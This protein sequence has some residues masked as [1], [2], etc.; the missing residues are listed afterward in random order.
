MKKLVALSVLSLISL[1]ALAS[2]LNTVL[3]VEAGHKHT[4]L[5]AEIL[6]S[7]NGFFYNSAWTKNFRDGVNVAS[8]GVGYQHSVGLV[9]GYVGIKAAYIAPKK[10][11]NG[12]AAPFGGGV[13]IHMTNDIYAYGEGYVATRGM[14]NAVQKYVEV[15]SGVAYTPKENVVLN[16]GYRYMGVDG[17]SE[18]PNH[19]LIDGAY[20][21]AGYKF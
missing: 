10:G 14:N 11:D 15:D 21:G 1:P 19:A 12:F 20:V 9:D 5:S 16:V 6:P 4:Q 13:R 3:G 18:T 8:A 7:E 2:D 17:K